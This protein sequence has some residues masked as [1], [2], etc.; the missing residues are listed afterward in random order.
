MAKEKSI[1]IR[2]TDELDKELTFK[3]TSIGLSK[4]EYIRQFITQSAPKPSAKDYGYLLGAV[5]RI[6][7]NIN[8]IAHNL[9][10]ARKSGNLNDTDYDSLLNMLIILNEN[11]KALLKE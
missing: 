4:S 8:Q 11:V 9:N 7:N 1:R 2:L 10:V 5:N 6:G 3:A